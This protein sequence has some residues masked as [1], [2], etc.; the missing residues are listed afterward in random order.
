MAISLVPNEFR[1]PRDSEEWFGMIFG[2][3][4]LALMIMNIGNC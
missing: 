4:G 2:I 3:L 1:L